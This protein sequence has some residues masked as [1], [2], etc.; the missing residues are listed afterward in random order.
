MV[1][2]NWNTLWTPPPPVLGSLNCR[3][4]DERAWLQML[5]H[6]YLYKSIV[7]KEERVSNTWTVQNPI[8]NADAGLWDY[9]SMLLDWK[10][11]HYSAMSLTILTFLAI[12][13]Q[14]RDRRYVALLCSTACACMPRLPG[15]HWITDVS[16]SQT[17]S[18]APNHVYFRGAPLYLGLEAHN[19]EMV[20]S[21]Y[22]SMI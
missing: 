3:Y 8:N 4:L 7:H 16:V 10:T 18:S 17:C 5:A 13:Q 21:K 20:R 9:L 22:T 6:I 12:V 1:T 2:Y 19:F 11:K 15:V 14:G